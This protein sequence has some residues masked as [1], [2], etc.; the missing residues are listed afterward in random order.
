MHIN[1]LRG[2]SVYER[3]N[4]MQLIVNSYKRYSFNLLYSNL[5]TSCF[6]NEFIAWI[7]FSEA[8]ILLCAFCTNS[9]ISILYSWCCDAL[10]ANSIWSQIHGVVMHWSL[11]HYDRKLIMIAKSLWS[12]IHTNKHHT[13]PSHSSS[14]SL[15]SHSSSFCIVCMV[16]NSYSSGSF[17][18]TLRRKDKLDLPPSAGGVSL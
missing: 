9:F 3:K 8:L 14:H 12:L 2:N 1:T 7:V 5:V 10:I 11:I 18:S 13:N 15:I 6:K 17:T 4:C 16:I